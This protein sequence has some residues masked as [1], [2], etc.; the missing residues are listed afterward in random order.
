MLTLQSENFFMKRVVQILLFIIVVTL[1]YMCVVSIRQGMVN[2]NVEDT[3]V[4]E[5]Y[6]NE[7][8]TP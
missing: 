2:E 8:P 4:F 3:S 5:R 1:I 7:N 6:E